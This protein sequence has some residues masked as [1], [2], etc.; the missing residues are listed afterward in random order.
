MDDPSILSSPLVLLL[1]AIGAV[2][3][4]V[5]LRRRA[6]HA[7]PPSSIR[8]PPADELKS[9]G[10]SEVRP[11][12]TSSSEP[13]PSGAVAPRVGEDAPVPR[14]DAGRRG[15]AGKHSARS[16]EKDVTPFADEPEALDQAVETPEPV[17]ADDPDERA[18][19]ASTPRAAIPG[20]APLLDSLRSSLAARSVAL[21][22]YDE[23]SD[24]YEVVGRAGQGFGG[25][26]NFPAPGNALHRVPADGSI[27]LLDAETFGAL[28]YHI[29]P[30]STVGHAAALAVDASTRHLLVADRGADEGPFASPQ[31]DLLG[32]FADLVGR[33]LGATGERP[34]P[35]APRALPAGADKASRKKHAPDS[36]LADLFAPAADESLRAPGEDSGAR[37]PDDAPA[38]LPQRRAILAEEIGLARD[39]GRPLA[40]ALVTSRGA[41]EAD[42]PVDMEGVENDLRRRL[43]ETDGTARVERFGDALMG[44]FGYFDAGSA[45][46]WAERVASS[47]DPVHIGIAMLADRH[48]PED[49]REDAAAAL[50][51]A[52]EQDETC[53]II[54]DDA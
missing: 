1:L 2:V 18:R 50:H 28:V 36:Q 29:R 34:P 49:L 53:V 16:P 54:S 7:R 17:A 44:A 6:S 35:G 32:E 13:E 4:F 3:A 46:E 52:Y 33:L 10:L 26:F 47:G 21:L 27:S 19:P 11:R 23:G 15:R 9:L 39:G 51:D 37:E 42:G 20:V 30:E 14:R 40:F 38:P 12:S 22:R 41:E 8:V 24:G 31:L 5:Y 48:G 25:K 45:E 43:E